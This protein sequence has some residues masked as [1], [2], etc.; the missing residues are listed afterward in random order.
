[1]LDNIKK[2]L[3]S[4]TMW[5]GYALTIFGIVEANLHLMEDNLG[6]NYGYAVTAVGIIVAVLRTTTTK[7]I[8]EL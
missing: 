2:S 6:T 5:F 4:E 7:P 8:Q 1:M 3:K